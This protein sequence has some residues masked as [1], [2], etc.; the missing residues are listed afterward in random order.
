MGLRD[1]LVTL[2]VFGSLPFILRRPYIGILVWSWL[3]YMNPHRL[4]YGFASTMPFAQIVAITLF[5]SILLSRDKLT[6][7][8]GSIVFVWIL[9]ILWMGVSTM[10]ALVPEAALFQFI[11]V[12]KIQ[13]ITFLT[14]LLINDKTK[15]DQLIW[16][17][18][19]SIG[20][21]S[22]KGG[23]FTILNAGFYRVYG[24][25]ESFIAEN[26]ALALATLMIIP[27]ML[28]LYRISRGRKWTQRLLISSIFLSIVSVAGSQSRGALVALLAVAGVFWLKSKTKT[29]SGLAV[30]L[31]AFGVFS[32]MPESWHERMSTITNYE[33]DASAMGRINAWAYSLNVAN[34]RLTGA[35][36][37]SWTNWTF[38]IYAPVPDDV[39]AAHSIYFSPLADHGW[40]GLILFV[41][42]LALTWYSTSLIIKE[43]AGGKT[44]EELGFLAKML[45]ISLV[46]YM[47]GGAFLSLTYFDLPWHMVAIVVIIRSHIIGA[48]SDVG[49]KHGVAGQRLYREV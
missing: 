12:I 24:P 47:A 14:L 17:I 39:H 21:F 37:E 23:I 42:I 35:G 26:N 20:F 36:L 43:S 33:E 34:D 18:V 8:K 3:S 1:I 41:L 45:Q 15:L 38:A 6:L 32:F 7:P 11:K 28:Y 5:I 16:V 27:L 30:V 40:P 10:F 31:V 13:L 22:F 48:S 9:F 19:A 49:A 44:T 2:M 25:S 29:L 4:A 46:A